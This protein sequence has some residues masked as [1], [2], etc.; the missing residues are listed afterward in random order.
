[1]KIYA[2]KFDRQLPQ[3][4][5]SLLLSSVGKDK[6]A[7]ILRFRD[8]RDAYRVLY[9]D[10]LVRHII[11]EKTGKSN[12]DITL[13][14]DTHSKPYLK[15]DTDLFFNI[16]H[17]GS[18]VVGTVDMQPVGIDIEQVMPIAEDV[19]QEVLSSQEYSEIK[20]LEES[21]KLSDFYAMWT[22]KES[23]LKALGKGLEPNMRVVHT[24]RLRNR[25]ILLSSHGIIQKNTFFRTYAL[26]PEY[27]MTV[28]CLGKDDFPKSVIIKETREITSSF[29]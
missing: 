17:S 25:K 28:C 9:G 21:Q 12:K 2:L 23:Y 20:D 3:E 10:L 22:I 8:W 29:H 13:A 15:T 1:M 5:F 6:R 18:W 26:D 27:R 7:R 16:S 11:K 14:V 4:L 19:M 24:Q